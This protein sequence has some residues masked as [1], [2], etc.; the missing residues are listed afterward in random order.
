M[1]PVSFPD[2]AL[3]AKVTV[4]CL[5]EE[6]VVVTV[7]AGTQ[8]GTLLRARG[9]G[10]PRLHQ[11]GK[12]DLYIVIE[13]KTPTSLTPRQRELLKEFKLEANKQTAATGM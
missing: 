2:A 6:K 5:S 10:M 11:K 13:V 7:P 9:K 4:P 12:G 3:G 1:M 8:H